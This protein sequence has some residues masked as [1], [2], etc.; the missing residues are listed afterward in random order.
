MIYCSLISF[1]L[2]KDHFSIISTDHFICKY[3]LYSKYTNIFHILSIYILFSIIVNLLG[4]EC[5]F[6]K[7]TIL[8][9]LLLFSIYINFNFYSSIDNIITF[10]KSNRINYVGFIAILLISSSTFSFV[11]LTT[12]GL[13]DSYESDIYKSNLKIDN[14][15]LRLIHFNDVYQVKQIMNEGGF[16]EAK[17]MISKMKREIE[18]LNSVKTLD[19]QSLV[20]FSGDFIPASIGSMPLDAL[21]MLELIDALGVNYA[22]LGNHDVDIESISEFRKYCN[23]KRMKFITSNLWVQENDELNTFSIPYEIITVSSYKIGIIGVLRK[24]TEKE[25]IN[26]EPID[27]HIKFIELNGSIKENSY[28]INNNKLYIKDE[29]EA[30]VELVHYLK[31]EKKCDAIIAITHLSMD[32]DIALVKAVPDITVVLG[33]HDH[34]PQTHIEG[35]PH[36]GTLIHKS[37]MN[38]QYLGVID[39]TF[40]G[41]PGKNPPILKQWKMISTSLS[42]PD[43]EMQLLIRNKE[44]IDDS[45]II[46][47]TLTNIDSKAEH[48]RTRET[49]IG[50][51]VCDSIR[52]I[53]KTNFVILPGGTFRGNRILHPIQYIKESAIYTELPF[54]NKMVVVEVS[55]KEL[56]AIIE[57]GLSGL[58]DGSGKFPQI[59][60]FKVKYDPSASPYSRVITI[61]DGHGKQIKLNDIYSLGVPDFLVQGGDGYGKYLSHKSILQILNKTLAEVVIEQ[62]RNEEIIAPVIDGRLQVSRH[63][64]KDET[65]SRD[66][67]EL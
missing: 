47:K 55:G 16:A 44:S 30:S 31:K 37:G 8:T 18:D 14:F 62:I 43:P 24:E 65:W 49:T 34:Y 6:L 59:S 12:D 40:R 60:G 21:S 36:D 3:F 41:Q 10:I 39:L 17:S 45:Q 42:H 61:L 23:S 66:F 58:D 20:I 27:N 33:G 28:P 54:K 64:L 46:G 56:L 13:F 9:Y 38:I 57:H 26:L 35:G 25:L 1:Q 52:K 48:V 2:N 19:S 51:F 5:S 4:F 53:L 32:E 22:T 15:T 29:I 67:K 11:D 7:Y 63:Y 50:N